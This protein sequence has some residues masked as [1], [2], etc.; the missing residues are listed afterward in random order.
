[1]SGRHPSKAKGPVQPALRRSWR[2]IPQ[3][4]STDNPLVLDSASAS[5]IRVSVLLFARYAEL[6]GRDR[7]DVE[8]AEPVTMAHVI[9]HLRTLPGGDQLPATVLMA[10]NLVQ[11]GTDQ[12]LE[13]GDQVALLPPMSGG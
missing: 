2:L 10:R 7:V 11:V 4:S 13:E 5:G 1:M 6:F 8:L 9:A 3:G 12:G